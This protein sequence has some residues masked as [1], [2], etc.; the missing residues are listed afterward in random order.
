MRTTNVDQVLP[1][2][3]S[4]FLWLSDTKRMTFGR[5]KSASNTFIL[6]LIVSD[7]TNSLRDFYDFVE[8]N[9]NKKSVDL[10]RSDGAWYEK[11]TGTSL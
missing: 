1:S 7:E 10:V 8:S 2:I 5:S 6:C 3:S 11:V 9:T 4:M